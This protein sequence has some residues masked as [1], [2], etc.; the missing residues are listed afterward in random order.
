MVI[1]EH[2]SVAAGQ[3]VKGFDDQGMP[4]P[5]YN[6]GHVQFFDDSLLSRSVSII[7]GY[8]ECM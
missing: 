4:F 8:P 6:L 3:I 1:D 7:G 2:K 5:R